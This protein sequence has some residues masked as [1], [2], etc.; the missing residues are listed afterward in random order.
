ML[1]ESCIYADETEIVRN[2]FFILWRKKTLSLGLS[3]LVF[4][5][6]TKELRNQ[7]SGEHDWSAV[8]VLV[9]V[10]T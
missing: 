3:V 9:Q 4:K 2:S 7:T 10:G 8:E 6:T 5:P 1:M